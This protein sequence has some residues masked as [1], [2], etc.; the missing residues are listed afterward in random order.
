M[1]Y[2]KVASSELEDA[3]ADSPTAADDDGEP[4]S[5]WS[6]LCAP[7]KPG[8]HDG[9]PAWCERI[10]EAWWYQASCFMYCVAGGL[11]LVHPE[12]L[13]RHMKFPWR[14][15]GLC[16]FANGFF[17]YMSDVEMWGRPTAWR[18]ADKVL[19]STNALLQLV[20]AANG[21]MGRATFPPESPAILGASVL[22]ALA[23]KWRA[24]AFLRAGDCDGF[25]KWHALWH[26]TLPI[27]ACVAQ[28]VLHRACDYTP[29][30]CRH[31]IQLCAG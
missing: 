11:L 16:V 21:L 17:S 2:I 12:P 15:M 27:G 7:R 26:Y 20:I 29:D 6:R 13:E 8:P 18:A 3:R 24:T 4:R 1:A 23:C 31:H 19:A 10:G 14:W 22:V 28:G 30:G 25:L 9:D 5:M